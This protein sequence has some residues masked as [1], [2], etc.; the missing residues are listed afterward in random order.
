MEEIVGDGGDCGRWRCVDHEEF[1][2]VDEITLDLTRYDLKTVKFL[3][4]FI[5]AINNSD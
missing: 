5:H 4:I 3:Q 2:K 1:T